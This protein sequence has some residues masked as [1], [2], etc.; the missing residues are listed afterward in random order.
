MPLMF[1]LD[2]W[3]FLKK[4]MMECFSFLSD[5]STADESGRWVEGR[6]SPLAEV[7]PLE[8]AALAGHARVDVVVGEDHGVHLAQGGG[9]RPCEP[10]KNKCN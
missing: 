8:D 6:V 4:K 3:F 5:L 7:D 2:D 9:G 10:R 1:F